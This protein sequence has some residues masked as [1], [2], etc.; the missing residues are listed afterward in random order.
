MLYKCLFFLYNESG[1]VRWEE[2]KEENKQ[3]KMEKV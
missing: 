1:E 2:N 3:K